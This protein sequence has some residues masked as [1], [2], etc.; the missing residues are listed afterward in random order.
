MASAIYQIALILGRDLTKRDL[1][2]IYVEFFKDL[3]EVKGSALKNL[4]N[5]LRVIDLEHHNII[6]TICLELSLDSAPKN[7][8]FREELAKQVLEL[9]KFY[10]N[11]DK[12]ESLLYLTGI[13]FT[14][15]M[16]KANRVREI[17]FDAVRSIS[18][19]D[20]I[21]FFNNF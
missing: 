11:K 10:E 4:A 16:D 7:W 13:A 2:P 18:I 21:K 1:V 5:F 14:L 12:E 6:L 17:A 8:R 19:F 15:L 3:D 20:C 9:I